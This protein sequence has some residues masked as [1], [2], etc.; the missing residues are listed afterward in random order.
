LAVFR[1]EM[2]HNSFLPALPQPKKVPCPASPE[3]WMVLS[4]LDQARME[5]SPA[6]NVVLALYIGGIRHIEKS[7]AVGSEEACGLLKLMAISG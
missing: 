1:I 5:V 3:L 2:G 4:E 6:N 7:S